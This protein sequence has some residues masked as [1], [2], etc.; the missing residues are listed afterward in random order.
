MARSLFRPIRVVLAGTGA[1]W[2]SCAV[3][4][5]VLG[6][7]V[8]GV[9]AAVPVGAL[10]YHPLEP[11]GE[12]RNAG[13]AGVWRVDN[14]MPTQYDEPRAVRLGGYVY[15]AGG[16]ADINPM[17]YQATSVDQFLRYDLVSQQYLQLAPMPMRLS[18]VGITTYNGDIYVVGGL[19]DDLITP[20]A[21]ARAFRYIT[22]ENR[23]VEIASLPSARGALGLVTVGHHM[24][25][26]S[27]VPQGPPGGTQ[28]T[29]AR[30]A[31]TH[32]YDFNTG[33]WSPRRPIPTARDHLG[34]TAYNGLIYAVGGRTAHNYAR[35][36]FERYDP[37]TDTWATLLPIPMGSSGIQI[38]PVSGRLVVASGGDDIANW[39][40]GRVFAY[41]PAT[42]TWGQLPA[43]PKPV[44]G[45]A[46][47]ENNG[48]LH[49]FGGSECAS[50]APIKDVE[51]LNIP[52]PGGPPVRCPPGVAR[53]VSF[54]GAARTVTASRRGTFRY[55]FTASPLLRGSALF[56]ATRLSRRE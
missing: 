1:W 43:I 56:K 14:P 51:S 34:V 27:G 28:Q 47:T 53:S 10:A 54:A 2:R 8:V 32:A 44:H 40:D 46:A 35:S 38:V 4:V 41:D 37:A 11:C 16:I 30:T 21:T 12:I 29:A 15:L 5:V 52:T 42:S 7:G 33:T 17:T 6:L 22:A 55:R 3:R 31:A 36:E 45:Y 25:A 23:W 26:I 49:V 13:A 20:G 24:Y 39:V 19:T 48:R 50:F 18:H 9:L